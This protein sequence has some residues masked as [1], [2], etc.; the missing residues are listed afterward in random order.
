MRIGCLIF[1]LLGALAW[2]Q[3]APGSAP[4]A[5]HATSAASSAQPQPSDTSASVAPDAAVLTI[6]GVCS[7]P[8]KPKAAPGAAKPALPKPAASDCKTIVTKEEFE[9]IVASVPNPSPQIK[10][11]IANALPRLIA[12]SEAAKKKGLD[13]TPQFKEMVRIQTMQLLSNEL[14]RSIQAEAAKVPPED[15]ESYYK[16]NTPAFEQFNL[17]RLFVP[18]ARQAQAEL[19]DEGEKNETLTEEQKKAKQE[20]EKA[21][22]AEG[23]QAMAKLA[24][25]LRAR[26]V[27]GEDFVKLQKGAFEAAGMK[28]ESPTVTLPKVR[29]SGLPP[30]HAAVFDLKPGDVSQVINDSSGHYI[31]K[32]VGKDQLT[33]DQAK[34]E[35]RT[36][37]Q[38]DRSREMMDKVNGS[39]Q[40]ESNEAYFG[41]G[42][43]GPVPGPRMGGVGGPRMAPASGTPS[44]RPQS[45]PAQAPTPTPAGKQD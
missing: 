40:V 22:A 33:F 17:E 44:P 25:D 8:P 15:I 19:K 18:R 24:E 37:M 1:I 20:A 5:Q 28:I 16:S 35:I 41:P 11:Q 26:A 45:G 30:A 2:G 36:R 12:M 34:E 3:A 42:G 27:A 23:E 31:Y 32:V 4:T 29:R 10:R 9:K 6:K 14:T 13:K 38:N 7:T 39:F 43:T 21:K